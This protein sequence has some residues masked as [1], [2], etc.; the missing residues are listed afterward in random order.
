MN[1]IGDTF[2][3]QKHYRERTRNAGHCPHCGR[4]CAP[5]YE[6]EE[7]RAYKRKQR[8]TQEKTRGAYVRKT[9]DRR[10]RVRG[11]LRRWTTVD[12]DTLL[13]FLAENVSLDEI[14]DYF[15]RTEGAIKARVR[16]L[17]F[18]TFLQ[19]PNY[20]DGRVFV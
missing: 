18:T 1:S 4:P 10:R 7:R 8:A 17:G 6:C 2:L 11:P 16:K 12:D 3:K 15:N 14:V 5:Y 20:G 9:E 13:Q 19:R